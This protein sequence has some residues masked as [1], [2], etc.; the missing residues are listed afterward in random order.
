MTSTGA[1]LS[2]ATSSS[3]PPRRRRCGMQPR[4]R[5]SRARGAKCAAMLAHSAARQ[6][7]P[8]LALRG[9]MATKCLG[10]TAFGNA[11]GNGIVD[12]MQPTQGTRPWSDKNYV[13]EYDKQSD[14]AYEARRS[15]EWITQSDAIQQRRMA[16]A[17]APYREQQWIEQSDAIQQRRM[18]EAS[19]E[20]AQE[21]F[22]ALERQY[23]QATDTGAK[24][25][26]PSVRSG[27]AGFAFSDNRDAKDIRLGF[28]YQS[29]VSR[30][31]SDRA[32]PVPVGGGSPGQSISAWDPRPEQARQAALAKTRT[33]LGLAVGGPVL[34]GYAAGAKLAGAPDDVVNN[35]GVAQTGV[36]LSLAA[37]LVA[38]G[39]ISLQP[40]HV[41]FGPGTG[42]LTGELEVAPRNANADQL[43]SIQRQNEATEFLSQRG[44]D[45]VRLPNAG[46]QGMKNPDAAINGQLADVYSPRTG[47]PWTIRDNIAAKVEHQAPNVVL[48]LVD[49]PLSPAQVANHLQVNPVP[50]N[51]LVIIKNGQVVVMGR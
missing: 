1:G 25:R 4:N 41:P 39:A 14:Q 33:Q 9:A 40:R 17:A 32:A 21:N 16:E 27:S 2:C 11:L 48:N 30:I 18:A 15:Q 42:S 8:M 13:N 47:N 50:V 12:S 6:P 49:S 51:N 31:L 3:Q 38:P 23:R 36:V 44:Y 46:P 37:P 5:A 34:V 7:A 22:R 43:R 19:A 35:I 10:P 20:V 24:P 26:A 28:S 29:Q 45:V